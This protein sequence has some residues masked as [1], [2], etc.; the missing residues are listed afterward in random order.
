MSENNTQK[1]ITDVIFK[2]AIEKILTEISDYIYVEEP[3]TKPEIDDMFDATSQEIDYYSSLISDVVSENRLWSS[4]KI[5]EEIAKSIL[6][7]NEYSD[8]LISNLSS[9]SLKYVESLPDTGD[10]STIYILK[11]ASEADPD[12]LNLFDG[13]QWVTIGKFEFDMSGYVTTDD[14]NTKLDKK[15]N[16]NE[17]VKVS[18][19]LTDTTGASNN[20]VLSASATV[21]ELDKKVNKSDI[22][23]NLTSTDT[24]KPLSANQGKV[25]KDEVDLKANDSDVI[26]KTDIV[27]TIDKSSTNDKIPSAGAIYNKFKNKTLQ[28]PNGTDIIAYADTITKEDVNVTVKLKDGLNCPYGADVIYNDFYY[29]IYNMYDDKFKRIVAYDIRKN[30]MYMLIKSSNVW[31]EWRKVCTTRIKD[32]DIT[33]ISTFEDETYVK[34]IGTNACNYHVTNGQCIVTLQTICL[35]TS[36]DFV[37]IVSGLPKPKITIYSNAIDRQMTTNSGAR[38][39]FQ[40]NT[41]GVLKV[42]C[43]YGDTSITG[44]RNLYATFSYPVAEE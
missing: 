32:V 10:S 16:D 23:D 29:T 39:V 30:D 26:K 25:L 6:E 38:G 3:Y 21:T 19:I 2:S 28:L 7:S 27:T 37:Q 4:K 12:T 44:G 33:Y 5:S 14:M 36:Q 42:V 17:V 9:I 11:S 8:N 15:A 1:I 41:T 31:R 24:D 40:L 22:V 35:S 18:D 20:N 43:N 34:P 13:T